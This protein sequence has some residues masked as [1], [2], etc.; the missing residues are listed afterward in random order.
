[1]F[2]P[3]EDRMRTMRGKVVGSYTP[4]GRDFVVWPEDG[5]YV[6]VAPSGARLSRHP[7]RASAEVA[8]ALKQREW[9]SA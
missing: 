8:R 9:G 1:M 6:V 5:G 2:N 3:K 4:P 7:D